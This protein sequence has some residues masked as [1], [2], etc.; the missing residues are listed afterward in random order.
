MNVL[1]S[2]NF[3][4]RGVVLAL[5]SLLSSFLLLLL[6]DHISALLELGSDDGGVSDLSLHPGVANDIG[7]TG[8]SGRVELKQ[9]CDQI[10]EFL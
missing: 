10:H 1:T 7:E 2:A 4:V 8:T 6:L 9:V 5:G 3:P